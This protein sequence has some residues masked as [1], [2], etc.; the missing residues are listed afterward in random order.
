MRVQALRAQKAGHK[1][2]SGLDGWCRI[3]L[4]GAF[5]TEVVHTK[6]RTLLAIACGRDLGQ[7]PLSARALVVKSIHSATICRSHYLRTEEA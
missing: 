2:R 4:P 7:K 3:Q 1:H 6:V 5:G